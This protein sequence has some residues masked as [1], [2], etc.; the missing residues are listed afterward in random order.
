MSLL[1]SQT[2]PLLLAILHGSIDSI[3]E[4]LSIGTSSL[5]ELMRGPKISDEKQYQVKQGS[6][7]LRYDNIGFYLLTVAK[8]NDVLSY[9]LKSD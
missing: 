9:L 5:R 1:A 2:N 3:K 7:F 8:N 6:S 4:I